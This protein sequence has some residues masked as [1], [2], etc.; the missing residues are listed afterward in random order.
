MLIFYGSYGTANC[1]AQAGVTWDECIDLCYESS[2]CYS[3]YSTSASTCNFCGFGG[4]KTIVFSSSET[5]TIIAVKSDETTCP[6]SQNLTT[7]YINK[8]RVCISGLIKLTR[9]STAICVQ[10]LFYNIFLNQTF[11]TQVCAAY[12]PTGTVIGLQSDAERSQLSPMNPTYGNMSIWIALEKQSG[13]F[14]WTDP[15]LTGNGSIS[16]A[17]GHPITG[18]NCATLQV[19]TA[20]IQSISCGGTSCGGATYCQRGILCAWA[21]E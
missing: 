19:G 3:A 13:S 16:W 17:S 20:L 1:T 5:T 9:T 18:Y 6:A 4:L 7:E 10:R 8:V 21:I 12:R 2:D 15:W 14:V 11:S